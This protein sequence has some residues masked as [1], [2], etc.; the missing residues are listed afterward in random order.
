LATPDE[1]RG[2]LDGVHDLLRA[3]LATTVARRDGH[4]PVPDG[5]EH[6]RLHLL[7]FPVREAI[8]VRLTSPDA[9]RSPDTRTEE[10]ADDE[11]T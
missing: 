10:P 11:H 3:A 7:A 8:G 2:L 6:V 1:L 9:D 5:A 4:E